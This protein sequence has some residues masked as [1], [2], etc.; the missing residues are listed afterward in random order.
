MNGENSKKP[1]TFEEIALALAK[2]YDSIFVIHSDDDSFVEYIVEGENKKLV[3]RS[4]GTDFYEAVKVNAR[5]QVYSED[6][7][8]FLNALENKR[9]PLK[10]GCFEMEIHTAS[11]ESWPFFAQKVAWYGRKDNRSIYLGELGERSEV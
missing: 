6:Q 7:E 8:Y 11:Y 4:A 5:A 2:D 1:I 3:Q 9:V 10:A